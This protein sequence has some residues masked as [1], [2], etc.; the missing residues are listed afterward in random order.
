MKESTQVIQL[1]KE[2]QGG[3]GKGSLNYMRLAF[4]ILLLEEPSFKDRVAGGFRMNIQASTQE[5]LTRNQVIIN[6]LTSHGIPC[7]L[8]NRKD[9]VICESFEEKALKWKSFK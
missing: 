6:L 3:K 8:N 1:R 2:L 9:V 5:Q 7:K 4:A